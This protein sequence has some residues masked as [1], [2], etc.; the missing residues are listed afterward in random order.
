[1]DPSRPGVVVGRYRQATDADIQMAVA[2]ADTDPDGWRTMSPDARFEVLGRVAQELRLS[3]GDLIGAAMADGGK[4]VLESDPEVSEAVDFLEFYRDTARWWQTMPT[5]SAQP[6][7]VVVVVSPWNFPIA[8]PCGGIAAA[9]AAGNTVILKPASDTVLVAWVMCQC[10]WRAGVPKSA[11]QFVPCSGGKEGRQLVNHPSVAAVVLTG[12]TETALTM[13]N[14][15]PRMN[16]FAETGGKN[17]TIVT[18]LSDREQAIKHVIQSAFGHSGQKCSATSLLLLEDEVYDD[19][20][21][22]HTLKDAVESMKIGSAWDLDTKVGPLIKPPSGD[23]DNALKVLDAGEEWLVTPVPDEHN[24]GLW[25]PGIKYGV[26]PGSYT[27]LTEFFG[28]VLGVM[29]FSKLR[30]AVAWVNQTGYGLT[31]GLQSL[32]EREW[33]YWLENLHAGTFI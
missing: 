26:V 5:V 9:L 19:A 20:A 17:A 14:D 28:P 18:A 24:S 8:I 7:G 15:N 32:D 22:R 10:F 30:D 6:V 1:M 16:L 33:E 4:T 3:R 23:L 13:L 29:R 21:F 27:H 25:S 31:S 2:T 12:G 11:L